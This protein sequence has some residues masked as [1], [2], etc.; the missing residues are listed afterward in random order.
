VRQVKMIG[1]AHVA[2]EVNSERLVEKHNKR[3]F[4]LTNSVNHT[5]RVLVILQESS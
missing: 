4:I 5:V 3:Q 2:K 1:T